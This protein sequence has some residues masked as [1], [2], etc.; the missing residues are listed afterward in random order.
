MVIKIEVSDEEKAKIQ[1]RG[2]GSVIVN[3]DGKNYL[4]T[5]GCIELYRPE[6]NG[7]GELRYVEEDTLKEYE[8][9]DKSFDDVKGKYS[10]SR[11]GSIIIPEKTVEKFIQGEDEIQDHMLNFNANEDENYNWDDFNSRS[12]EVTT[13]PS[14]KELPYQTQISIYSM[15]YEFLSALTTFTQNSEYGI[16]VANLAVN[17]TK[18]KLNILDSSKTTEKRNTEQYLSH[19]IVK[20]IVGA[21]AKVMTVGIYGR[22][23]TGGTGTEEYKSR[24]LDEFTEYEKLWSTRQNNYEY[25]VPRVIRKNTITTEYTSAIQ[26]AEA[27][28]WFVKKKTRYEREETDTELDD[29]V[30]NNPS[31]SPRT[32]EMRRN[33]A[34]DIDRYEGLNDLY[35]KEPRFKEFIEEFYK[36]DTGKNLNDFKRELLDG[37]D[38]NYM[39]N[40]VDEYVENDIKKKFY[41]IELHLP[42]PTTANIF[43]L[44]ANISKC[45]ENLLKA[46]EDYKNK[47]QDWKIDNNS[48]DVLPKNIYNEK[49]DKQDKTA[50]Y[51]SEIIY[52][53]SDVGQAEDNTDDFI[54]LLVKETNGNKEYVYYRNEHGDNKAPILDLM[55]GSEMFFQL[56]ANNNKTAN[57]EDAMRFVLHKITGED[58]GVTD[59][60]RALYSM[61]N[62][63]TGD[64]L[65]DYI[66][67]RENSELYAFHI[68]ETTSCSCVTANHYKTIADPTP[69]YMDFAYGIV[70]NPPTN[71]DLF[72]EFGVSAD[73]V[74][75]YTIEGMEVT[76]LSHEQAERLFERG[77]DKRRDYV[78]SIVPSDLNEDQINALVIISYAFGNPGNINEVYHLYK[79]GKI[80]QF[81]ANYK[82]SRCKCIFRNMS[83]MGQ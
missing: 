14:L 26:I 23:S 66:R 81:K 31:I 29:S 43:P 71:D 64:I 72:L 3:E 59:F 56:L 37:F 4:R 58:Y 25:E 60:R 36:K 80:D 69:G 13:T 74:R 10:I 8:N 24:W 2:R 61:Q 6:F 44:P 27:E 68:G 65:Y 34:F 39:E 32:N 30:E 77:V 45:Y 78:K 33:M 62:F 73:K 20:Y 9:G 15:P 75:R 67:I 18:L 82:V 53:V 1:Q 42:Y 70:L 28:S 50:Y 41:E 12:G 49:K 46:I 76:E 48:Y 79:E 52:N 35:N 5:T 47:S 11:A 51:K 83:W 38:K 55:S 16:A 57:L 63:G 17:K 54:K 7:G 19:S 21:N 40:Y 22:S